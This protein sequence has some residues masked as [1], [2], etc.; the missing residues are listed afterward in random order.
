MDSTG[1]RGKMHIFVKIVCD[2]FG[3]LFNTIIVSH[4]VDIEQT[5]HNLLL[6][7]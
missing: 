1:D 6:F 4:S 5:S 7:F 3:K 2:N